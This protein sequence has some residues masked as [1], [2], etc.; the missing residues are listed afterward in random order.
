MYVDVWPMF[1]EVDM[2]NA[3]IVEFYGKDNIRLFSTFAGLLGE[4]LARQ[5]YIKKCLIDDNTTIVDV[6]KT[7]KTTVPKVGL[8]YKPLCKYYKMYGLSFD[9]IPVDL[10]ADEVDC[11]Y[12]SICTP[13]KFACEFASDLLDKYIGV[14]CSDIVNRLCSITYTTRQIYNEKCEFAL[15]AGEALLAIN[16]LT[17]MDSEGN[18]VLNKSVLRIYTEG[19]KDSYSAISKLIKLRNNVY[20]EYNSESTVD[21]I[22]SVLGKQRT[23]TRRVYNSVCDILKCVH[24]I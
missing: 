1:M 13:H 18:I 12:I 22:Y 11:T 15:L 2:L 21:M 14:T 20:H 10:Y 19:N 3:D 7:L 24:A 8:V 6:L 4:K 16:T 9:D 5:C 23:K 17:D